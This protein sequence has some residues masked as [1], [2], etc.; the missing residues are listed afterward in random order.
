MTDVD[1]F[2]NYTSGRLVMSAANAF[3]TASI[4]LPI[5][6]GGFGAGGGRRTILEFL[7]IK[8]FVQGTDLLANADD[9]QVS[10]TSGATP[11]AISDWSNPDTIAFVTQ[12]AHVGANP[13]SLLTT[14]QHRVDLQS[15]DGHGQ[16]V[17]VANINV[18]ADSGGMAAAL[19]IR[20]RIYYRFVN[21]PIE[22]FVGIVQSQGN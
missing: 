6:S 13:G 1:V 18:S 20:W 3:T 16:L 15:A 8:V 11:T 2:P 22:E 7:W 4:T 9:Y 19:Q 12:T 21:V 14:Q 10:F 17:A 5:V